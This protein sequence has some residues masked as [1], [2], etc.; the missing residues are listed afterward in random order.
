MIVFDKFKQLKMKKGVE[1]LRDG[2]AHSCAGACQSLTQSQSPLLETPIMLILLVLAVIVRENR[3]GSL[4]C[5]RRFSF[6]T[7]LAVVRSQSARSHYLD[8]KTN[9]FD[10]EENGSLYRGVGVELWA[11]CATDVF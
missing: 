3:N 11:C 4:D 7:F 8:R 5:C 10:H 2:C 1:S 6:A 9:N